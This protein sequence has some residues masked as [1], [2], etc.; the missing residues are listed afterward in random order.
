[1]NKES[2]W[3]KWARGGDIV[4]VPEYERLASLLKLLRGSWLITIA[5]Y[6]GRPDHSYRGAT[7]E[8]N[9]LDLVITKNNK[10][11]LKGNYT[12]NVKEKPATID[13]T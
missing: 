11:L 3:A 8:F 1:M 7:V 4:R 5:I 13:I 12:L 10:T 6:D 2:K 9:A